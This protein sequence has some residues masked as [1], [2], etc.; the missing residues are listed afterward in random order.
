VLTCGLSGSGKTSL[1]RAVATPLGALHV[2]SDIERK[3]IAGLGPLD[4]S[5]SPPDGGIYS[6]DFTERTYARLLDCATNALLGG[7]SLIVDAAFLKRVERRD[8]LSLAQ[9]MDVPAAILQ[10]VAPLAVLRERLE[11]RSRSGDDASEAGVAI[12]A[13]QPGYWEEFDDEERTKVVA[14]D[15]T[16]PD[17]ATTALG[18]LRTLGVG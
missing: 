18:E 11:L 9:R 10:C 8:L 13:R 1:A 14:V 15:T 17:A 3:R 2:R 4:D 6:R 7:E 12:L 5:H 16:A